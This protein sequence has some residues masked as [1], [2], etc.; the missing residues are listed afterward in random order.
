MTSIYAFALAALTF[1]QS[2]ADNPFFDQADRFFK[3]YVKSGKV[4]YRSLVK[5]TRLLDSLV[6]SIGSYELRNQPKAVQKAF[7]VNAYNILVIKGVADRY[8]I[9]SPIKVDG[10][11]KEI[12]FNVAG[13]SITLDQ[14]EFNNLFV[15]DRDLRLHFVLNCGATSCPTLYSEAILPE[16]INDQLDYST[17]MVMDRDDYVFVDH[18][19]KTVKV[20]KIFEWYKDMFEADGQSIRTFINYNRF[21]SIPA[22]Y[23][24]VFMEYDWTLNQVR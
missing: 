24:I 20:S 18:K 16:K 2:P 13:R 7:Y 1:L 14:L 11:F 19:S 12:K 23:P 22:S 4:D 9:E 8:P 21:I 3:T 17:Q 6:T 5:D 15:L 10:F